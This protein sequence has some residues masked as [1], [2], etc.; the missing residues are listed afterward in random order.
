MSDKEEKLIG[1]D[2]VEEVTKALNK[3][4]QGKKVK[5][6]YAD[7]FYKD[8]NEREYVDLREN[9]VVVKFVVYEEIRY[10][11]TIT[12][13]NDN[14]TIT[15]SKEDKRHEDYGIAVCFE[16]SNTYYKLI[17]VTEYHVSRDDIHWKENKT[18]N[19]VSF[20]V[21]DNFYQFPAVRSLLVE[22]V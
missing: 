8:E 3:N 19:G 10:D 13:Y 1:K 15:E 12:T 16:N 2:I 14:N 7:A 4:F 17:N 20:E 21:Y 5:I 22:T 6:T 9:G 18:E 11:K